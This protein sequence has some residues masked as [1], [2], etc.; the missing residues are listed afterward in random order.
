MTSCSKENRLQSRLEGSWVLERLQVVDGQ[1]VVH[2]LEQAEGF[3]NLNFENFSSSGDCSFEI[4]DSAVSATFYLSFA[5]VDLYLDDD[6][7]WL[8]F[9]SQEYRNSFKL[10]LLTKRDLVLEYYDEPNFQLRKF[11]F[12]KSE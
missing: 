9:G 3:L 11:V 2:V 10:I 8:T 7:E 1:D 4:V 5:G 12:I 6:L